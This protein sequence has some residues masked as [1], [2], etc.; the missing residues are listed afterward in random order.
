MRFRVG[1]IKEIYKGRKI[2]E[3]TGTCIPQLGKDSSKTNIT[4]YS[5]R[6]ER[7]HVFLIIN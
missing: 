3:V 2:R 7:V 6:I 1:D 4:H 5:I